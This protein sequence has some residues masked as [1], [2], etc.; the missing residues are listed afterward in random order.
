VTSETGSDEESGA[1]PQQVVL[2]LQWT[3]DGQERQELFGPWTQGNPETEEGSVAHM[4]EA[5][6]FIGE[7]RRATGLELADGGATAHTGLPGHPL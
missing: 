4:A 2:Q 7:W 3:E 5:H 1:R 6:R